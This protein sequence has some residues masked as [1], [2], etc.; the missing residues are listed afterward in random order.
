VKRSKNKA[1][2][3]LEGLVVQETAGT[4]KVVGKDGTVRGESKPSSSRSRAT[5][6]WETCLIRWL[7]LNFDFLIV[8]LSLCLDSVLPKGNTLFLLS[9]PAYAFHTLPPVP[10]ANQEEPQSLPPLDP[11][12]PSNPLAFLSE[13]PPT[14]PAPTSKHQAFETALARVP[15]IEIDILGSAFAFRSE[16]RAGRKFKPGT[17]LDQ[18]W[19][20]DWLFPEMFDE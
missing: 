3:G 1:L 10:N 11:I 13:T 19:A 20:A 7:T 15:R 16:D 18:G 12:D 6:K 9:F 14:V 8:Q 4:F 5:K 2:Q 17:V